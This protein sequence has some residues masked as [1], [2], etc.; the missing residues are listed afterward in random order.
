MIQL[1]HRSSPYLYDLFSL[2]NILTDFAGCFYV[3][4]LFV[5]LGLKGLSD[6]IAT[7]FPKTKSQ[8]CIVH[9]IR[10]SVKFVP[11]KDRK[12][13][14]ADLKKIYGAVNL[15]DAEY[16]LEEFREKW[17][18]VIHHLVNPTATLLSQKLQQEKS[19]QGTFLVCC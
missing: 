7:T 9:Q 5:E 19:N 4:G 11:H 2:K 12:V 14:C 17:N 13:I 18:I 1:F 8:L 16:A 15:D 3:L 10:N 6:A